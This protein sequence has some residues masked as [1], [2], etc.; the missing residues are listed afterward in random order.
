MSIQ[1][2]QQLEL[3]IALIVQVQL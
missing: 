1:L 2:I 3:N